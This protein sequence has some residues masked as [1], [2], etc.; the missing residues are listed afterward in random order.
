[1]F[2]SKIYDLITKKSTKAEMQSHNRAQISD[3]WNI[4]SNYES[5]EMSKA[6]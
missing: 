2:E 3:Q 5:Y 1:M 4:K 6:T